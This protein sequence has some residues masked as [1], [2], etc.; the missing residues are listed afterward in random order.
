MAMNTAPSQREL[1]QKAGI[2]QTYASMILNGRR[3]PSRVTAIRI[4][5]TTG[6]KAS[7]IAALTDADIDAL[8]WFEAACR[9]T[10]RAA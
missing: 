9:A 2:S 6:W 4:Y 3:R 1:I 10:E 5:R 8:E 7:P